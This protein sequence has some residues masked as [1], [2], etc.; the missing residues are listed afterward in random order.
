MSKFIVISVP[1]EQ[2][3]YDAVEALKDLHADG[4][5]TLYGYAV[6]QRAADGKMVVKDEW[7]EGPLGTGVGA[8]VGG[9]VGLLGGPVGGAIGLG[10]GS[11]AGA[12]HD[13]FEVGVSDDF[14]TSVTRKLAPGNTA[15]A[16]EI[17]EDWITPLDL[18]A[19]ALGASVIRETRMDL[20]DER[21]GKRLDQFKAE[22]A[23]RKKERAA[24][25]AEKMDAKLANE[26]S[27]SEEK[28]RAELDKA[29]ARMERARQETKAK[30]DALRAQA[31]KATPDVRRRIEERIA[32]MQS[33]D[34]QR[35]DKLEQA[36]RLSQQALR[37]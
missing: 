30:I 33:D 17:S 24:A 4:S 11:V 16:A 28:L 34:D 3:A 20:V 37:A 35:T 12:L 6:V 10:A 15:V 1:T 27:E 29:H 7:G 21:I 36:Y 18:R 23:Q 9:F 26:I 19:E 13:L 14:L 32:D 2:K 25:K 5:L 8:L 22:V 31:S